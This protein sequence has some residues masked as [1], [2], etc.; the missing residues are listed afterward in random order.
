MA[1]ADTGSVQ[2]GFSVGAKYF[3]KAVDRNRI[4]RLMREAYRLQ[5][6]IQLYDSIADSEQL[7]LLS[8]QFVGK[9][10]Y[11]HAFFEKKLSGAFKKL[12]TNLAPNELPSTSL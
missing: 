9:Q 8:L 3:K 4:K 12:L 1:Q 6:Q 11:D 5:K 2:A 10:I 7:L